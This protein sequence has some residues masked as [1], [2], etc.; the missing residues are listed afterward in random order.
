VID[1][2]YE[3]LLYIA[4]VAGRRLQLDISRGSPEQVIDGW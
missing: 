3:N 4:E 1:I 2:H